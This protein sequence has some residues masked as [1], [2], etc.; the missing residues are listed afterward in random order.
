[1]DDLGFAPGGTVGR[2]ARTAARGER[3]T[4][5]GAGRAAAGQVAQK[6]EVSA[7]DRTIG[8]LQGTERNAWNLINFEFFGGVG[9]TIF[10]GLAAKL[11]LKRSAVVAKSAFIAPTA[12]LRKTTLAEWHQAPRHFMES[13]KGVAQDVATKTVDGQV[14]VDEASKAHPW[15][16]G[17][18]RKA[19]QL[20]KSGKAFGDRVGN[21]TGKVT[22]PIGRFFGR[23]TRFLS[24]TFPFL[25]RW[26]DGLANFG[27]RHTERGLTKSMDKLKATFTTE[28]PGFWKS[29]SNFFTRAKPA[30]IETPQELHGILAHV[31][32]AHGM[33]DAAAR[34]AKLT[35]AKEALTKL[36]E[37]KGISEGVAKHMGHVADALEHS[38]GLALSLEQHAAAAGGGLMGLA[39]SVGQ[40]IGRTSLLNAALTVGITAG[41]GAIMMSTHKENRVAREALKDMTADIGDAS[42]PIIV[43]ASKMHNK[44]GGRRWVAA[45]LNSAVQGIT[46]G[47]LGN[48]S[49][50][51]IG[52]VMAAQMGLMG[53]GAMIVPENML[54]NAYASLKQA[55][56]GKMQLSPEQ[57]T[58]F[59]K[60]LVGAVPAF[61]KQSGQYNTLLE[62]IAEKVAE[63]N[64]SVRD[65]M[66]FIAN[67]QQ[68]VALASEVAATQKKAAEEALAA[69]QA[70]AAAPAAPAT[71]KAAN[72]DMPV[73]QHRTSPETAS[74]SHAVAPAADKPT[75]SI[76]AARDTHQGRVVEVQRAVGQPA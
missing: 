67:Q 47:T 73:A 31:S 2:V 11:G 60:Q 30:T 69:K 18:E 28:K 27:R 72:D 1:M 42:H 23:I 46:L 54:L 25:D 66:R 62:P 50:G 14:A 61:A 33:T 19:E 40:R 26:S 24:K 4:V 6:V 35:E 65:T 70:A 52:G 13:V 55:E 39:K 63:R 64:M 34:A 29:I 49:G 21:V 41:V 32:E 16:A 76:A 43:E 48:M 12:A 56:Q 74:L 51:A 15:I 7:E 3:R 57:R 17:A 71:P 20:G 59:I 44:Q 22:G 8:R 38:H 37:S 36:A 53:V 75:F 68:F 5:Q 45:G 9:A 10:G 58:F